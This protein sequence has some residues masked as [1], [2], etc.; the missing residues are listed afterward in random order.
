MKFTLSKAAVQSLAQKAA[1]ASDLGHKDDVK[2]YFNVQNGKLS[3][4]Y[5]G[6]GN[7][8]MFSVD[9]TLVEGAGDSFCC[10]I[11]KFLT[12]SKKCKADEIT[13]EVNGQLI[14]FNVSDRTQLSLKAYEIVTNE[15]FSKYAAD[16]TASIDSKMGEHYEVSVTNE[17]VEFSKLLNKYSNA[18]VNAIKIVD[19]HTAIFSSSIFVIEKT[20]KED[21]VNTDDPIYLSADCIG[22][23]S[24]YSKY[25]KDTF[26]LNLSKDSRWVAINCEEFTAIMPTE[27]IFGAIKKETLDGAAPSDEDKIVVKLDRE[28]ISEL[29]DNFDGVFDSSW[30]N[31]VVNI[32]ST[33][34]STAE[35][36]LAVKHEDNSASL[37]VE[38]PIKEAV[39][40]DADVNVLTSIGYF[41]DAISVSESEEFEFVYSYRTINEPH[42]QIVLLN[43]SDIKAILTKLYTDE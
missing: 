35:S 1:I 7:G 38:L 12:Y 6:L 19:K 34:A 9:A 5:F 16:I 41:A 33:P 15:Q 4:V 10:D 40:T 11:S 39:Q 28:A 14:T 25:K 36:S 31:K 2:V 20:L 27:V 43:G 37:N 21:V 42:G 30:S 3:V 18:G 29:I 26:T 13:I 22:L 8:F 24:Q 32:I 17:L 23:I